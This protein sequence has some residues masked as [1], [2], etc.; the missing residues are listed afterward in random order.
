MA[1]LRDIP[2]PVAAPKARWS[3]V[4]LVPIVA[5]V[6]GLSLAVK[7]YIDQGPTITISFKTAEG[8]EPGKT[9]IRYRGVEIGQVTS[10]N[11]FGKE[12]VVATAELT[13]GTETGL[14]EDT[15]FWVVRARI[16][17][18]TVTGLGTLIS[19]AYISAD[20]GKSSKPA[21]HFVGLEKAP[22]FT[23]DLPGKQYVLRGE[24]LGSLDVGSPV[25]FRRIQVG[26]VAS[27][28][29]NPDGRGVTLTIFIHAPYDRYVATN[30]RFWHASGIDVALDASG[31]KINTQGLVSMLVG[32]IAFATPPGG[33]PASPA[34]A[35]AVFDLAEDRVEGMRQPDRVIDTYLMTFRQSARGLTI[36]A[37][38]DFRGIVIGEVAAIHAELD[39]KTF[40]AR[41][42]IEV[43]IYPERWAARR[44]RPSKEDMSK[45]NE[46]LIQGLIDKGMRAQLRT[47][48][49]VTGALYIALDFFPGAPKHKVDFSQSPAEL[50]TVPGAL[51]GLQETIATF[52]KKL[53]KVPLDEIGVNLNRT[54]QDVNRLVKR[55]DGEVAPEARDALAEGRKTLIELRATLADASRALSSVERTAAPDAQV[56]QEVQQALREVGRAARSVHLL[57]D[58]LERHPEA[59]ITG[60]RE[61]GK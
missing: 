44:L 1:E 24:T 27:Y 8:L 30:T 51:E 15:R 13:K 46:A 7:A 54:L 55:L 6:I 38:V 50:P 31:L 11:L 9:K 40:D 52:A 25:V 43:N 34:A 41:M 57:A 33:Q 29:L 26:Q 2:E 19:G 14:V 4:W 18:G 45:R 60:K 21:R 37:P 36:G 10:V 35:D 22:A 23:T 28:D 3:W 58:Y 5:V 49:L 39:P 20:P 56:V 32:G 47:G 59:L 16:S 17:G 42:V 12:G 61:D 48:N 53:D